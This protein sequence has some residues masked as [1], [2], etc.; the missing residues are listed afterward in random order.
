MESLDSITGM[1]QNFQ[2]LYTT[3]SMVIG[4]PYLNYIPVD[5]QGPVVG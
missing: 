3:T 5:T 2:V 4:A 1:F